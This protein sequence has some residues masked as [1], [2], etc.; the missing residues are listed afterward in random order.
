MGW[1]NDVVR[2]SVFEAQIVGYVIVVN[3]VNVNG[4]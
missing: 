3:P 1:E 4:L 2:T